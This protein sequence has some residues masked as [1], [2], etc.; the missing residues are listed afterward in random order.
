MFCDRC[1]TKTEDSAVFCPNCGKALKATTVK[2]AQGR[3]AGHLQLVAILWLAIAAFR[4]IP[5]LVLL[6]IFGNEFFPPGAPPF[7]RPLLSAIGVLF[8]IGGALSVV[9]GCGLLTKQS[10]ARL[11]AV[12]MAA[13]SLIDI[14][15]GT[16]LGVYTLWVLLPAESEREYRAISSAA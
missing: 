15:F 3:I 6:T 12:A 14:P 4:V 9:T 13:V 10:W 2:A 7:V 16:A 8:L 5:G 1:G 11:L